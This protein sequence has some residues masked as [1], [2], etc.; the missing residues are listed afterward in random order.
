MLHILKYLGCA[1]ANDE[2]KASAYQKATLRAAQDTDKSSSEA[3]EIVRSNERLFEAAVWLSHI[4]RK[5]SR[6]FE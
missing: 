3:K 2:L 6:A 5:V 4:S 1:N